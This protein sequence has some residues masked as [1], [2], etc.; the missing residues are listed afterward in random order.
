MSSKSTPPWQPV[1]PR[2]LAK[3]FSHLGWTGF[4][5]QIALLLTPLLLLVYV[6]FSSPDPAQQPGIDLGNYLSYGSLLVMVFTTFWFY[7]YTRIGKKIVDAESRPSQSSVVRTLWI[8]LWAGCIGIFFSLILMM[9][10]VWRLLFV[11][12]ANPQT[13]IQIAKPLGGDP[14][15]SLSA[16]DA[17]SLTSLLLLL[18]AELVVLTFSLWLLFRTTRPS[19]TMTNTVSGAPQPDTEAS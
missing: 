14:A 9:N 17:A 4:W 3:Q 12:M 19:A 8:G 1:N 7:R 18:T 15:R 10:A 2:G 11:L 5:I 6:L 16:M 13:G